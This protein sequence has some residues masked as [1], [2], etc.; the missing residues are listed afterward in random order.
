MKRRVDLCYPVGNDQISQ[1]G[2]MTRV[3]N[4]ADIDDLM[5][6][7]VCAGPQGIVMGRKFLGSKNPE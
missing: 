7:T 4:A 2:L 1:M 3:R 5:P 6:S